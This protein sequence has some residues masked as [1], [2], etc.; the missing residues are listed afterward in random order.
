MKKSMWF[1][2]FLILFVF[3]VNPINVVAMDD[4]DDSSDALIAIEI[5]N[6]LL[7]SG[8]LIDS[9]VKMNGEKKTIEKTYELQD[10]TTIID[11]F[12]YTAIRPMS[13]KGN[14]TAQRT[15]TIS[16]W[17]TISITASFDWYTEG[18]FSYVRCYSMTTD[19]KLEENVAVG[20]WDKSRTSNYVSIGSANAQVDYYFYNSKNPTQ[21][22]SG[23]F[24]ITCKDDGTI[25]DNG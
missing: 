24:K 4:V 7:D 10:G 21:K 19:R 2:L 11:T 12:E 14:D 18:M 1:V 9:K 17:A 22:K 3:I 25:S 8:K 23:T 15:L 16:G 13:A 20:K 5:D 6:A